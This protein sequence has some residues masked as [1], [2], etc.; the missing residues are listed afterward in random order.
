[1]VSNIEILGYIAAA[2]TTVAFVPQVV[3]VY[4]TKNTSSISLLM[5][6]IFNLGLICWGIYGI[7]LHQ[8]PII[9]ANC[10]TL[11]LA[12]YILLMKIKAVFKT[13]FNS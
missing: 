11:A 8:L 2:L 9:L 13:K 4:K 1:M 6:L 12:M 7:I 5:F 10:V 3:L